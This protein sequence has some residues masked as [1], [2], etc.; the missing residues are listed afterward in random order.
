MSEREASAAAVLRTRG[1]RK[2][3]GKGDALLVLAALGILVGVAALAA[4]PAR[5]VARGS[6][7]SVLR[8]ETA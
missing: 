4:V 5:A 2:E 3:F 8:S 7:S 6:V 1:L